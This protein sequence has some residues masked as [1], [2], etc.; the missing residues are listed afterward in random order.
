M[1]VPRTKISKRQKGNRRSH[2]AL[3]AKG[4]STC[5]KCNEIRQPHC[6]CKHCGFYAGKEVLAIAES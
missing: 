5:P 2:H 1:P 3:A 6:V 4:T